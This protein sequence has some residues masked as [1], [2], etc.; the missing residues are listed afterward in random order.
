M[1]YGIKNGHETIIL[2]VTILGPT[3]TQRACEPTTGLLTTCP[4]TE[5]NDHPTSLGVK[6]GQYVRSLSR[7]WRSKLKL[8]LQINS[9][10]NSS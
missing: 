2:I 1:N 9:Y 10:L 8:P 5:V 7:C 6:C 3:N 4:Q